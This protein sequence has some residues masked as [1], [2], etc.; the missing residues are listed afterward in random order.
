MSPHVSET[1][2]TNTKFN[3]NLLRDFSDGWG[4]RNEVSYILTEKG[5]IT[6]TGR[7]ARQQR[8]LDLCLTVHHQYRQSNIRVEE[9][10]R[11]N[12]NLLTIKN[13]QRDASRW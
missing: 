2:L 12:N 9:P 1:P 4:R 6:T 3:E 8:Y 13:Y 5:S 11:C 7:L 10:T